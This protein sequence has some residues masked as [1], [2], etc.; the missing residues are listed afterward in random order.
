MALIPLTDIQLTAATALVESG[1]LKIVPVD[2]ARAAAF[3]QAANAR[4]E[5]IPLLTA[6]FVQY[7]LAYDACHDV[8]EALLAA[9][10]Y[11]T[12]NGPGQHEALGRF[13]QAV[14]DQPPGNK[15][16]RQFD[17]LRRARNQ[18]RYQ[19]KPVGAAE[20]VSAER[21]ARVLHAAALAQ[22]VGS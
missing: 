6:P 20:A 8:G 3:L 7:G 10:G 4:I 15:A 22:G 14:L 5:Q 17:R 2:S 1:R 16:A 21:A 9:Y 19:A 11:R 13:L 18:D 12:T